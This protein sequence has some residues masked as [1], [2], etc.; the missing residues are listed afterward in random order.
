MPQAFFPSIN[1][2]PDRSTSASLPAGRLLAV[3]VRG[4]HRRGRELALG[5][6]W[7]RPTWLGDKTKAIT[8]P[9][10]AGRSTSATGTATN[11]LPSPVGHFLEALFAPIPVG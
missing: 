3:R 8:P 4:P 5:R 10:P 11:T 7:S 2:R 6:H 1:G 9:A